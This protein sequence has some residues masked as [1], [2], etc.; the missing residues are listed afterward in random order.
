MTV[1]TPALTVEQRRAAVVKAVAARRTRAEVSRALKAGR[2]SVADLLAR[3][4]TD[5]ALAGMRASAVLA[6]LPRYGPTRAAA[7]MAELRISPS[8]RLRGLGR[9]QRAG[10]IGLNRPADPAPVSPPPPG[11]GR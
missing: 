1:P 3:A 2:I 10:L 11:P 9:A 7:A 4:E 6:A 8:R 5:D